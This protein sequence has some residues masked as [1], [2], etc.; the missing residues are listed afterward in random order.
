MIRLMLT[1]PFQPPPRFRY[2]EGLCPLSQWLTLAL[3]MMVLCYG[4]VGR[5][6]VGAGV[7][8]GGVLQPGHPP[9]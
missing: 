9:N 4:L 8:L 3:P 2:H 5:Q 7:V 6:V 1:S